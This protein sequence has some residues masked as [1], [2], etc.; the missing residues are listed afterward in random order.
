MSHTATIKHWTRYGILAFVALLIWNFKLYIY[1]S[2][3]AMSSQTNFRLFL[4]GLIGAAII[5]VYIATFFSDYIFM[6]VWFENQLIFFG[7]CLATIGIIS[8]II[9]GFSIYVIVGCLIG[10]I[11]SVWAQGKRGW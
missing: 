8:G 5:V 4:T 3:L 2:K 9:F 1:I 10:V 6:C 7:Q 11:A